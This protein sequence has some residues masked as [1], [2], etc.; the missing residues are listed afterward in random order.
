MKFPG[1]GAWLQALGD[2]KQMLIFTQPVGMMFSLVTNIWWKR[3]EISSGRFIGFRWMGWFILWVPGHFG[4][5]TAALLQAVAVDGWVGVEW[6][7]INSN[8]NPEM[9]L[10]CDSC[11]SN[12]PWNPDVWWERQEEKW[13]RTGYFSGSR[14]FLCDWPLLFQW[15]YVKSPVMQTTFTGSKVST[16]F[17]LCLQETFDLIQR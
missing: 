17:F 6:T 12:F 10:S 2:L 3:R 5:R 13:H 16:V 4:L 14:L 1:P 7:F 8:E 11:D 15:K 9:T